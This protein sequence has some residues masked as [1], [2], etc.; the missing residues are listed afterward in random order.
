MK[1]EKDHP[2]LDPVYVHARRE[3]MVILGLFV[4][5]FIWAI[6][7]YYLDGYFPAQSVTEVHILWGVPRWVF[8][9][10][11]LPWCF[12][13]VC[14]FV[15]VFGFMRDDDLGEN[16]ENEDEPENESK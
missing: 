10:I 11:C 7:V 3:A 16:D 8:F 15:F 14:T 12:S 13:I 5:C 1:T 2:Q 9:G 6:S 4:V